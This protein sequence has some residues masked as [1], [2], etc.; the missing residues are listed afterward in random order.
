MVKV[1]SPLPEARLHANPVLILVHQVRWAN[2]SPKNL[3]RVDNLI[4]HG[5]K[6]T[7]KKIR[8]F[9]DRQTIKSVCADLTDE[10]QYKF[11]QLYW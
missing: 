1:Q 3:T 5:N 11:I 6:N 2:T 9:S 8:A 4:L 7:P 10:N